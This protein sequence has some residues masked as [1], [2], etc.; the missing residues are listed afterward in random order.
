VW[1]QGNG[2][3]RS[4]ACR[5][6]SRA[7]LGRWAKKEPRITGLCTHTHTSREIDS[8]P[9]GESAGGPRALLVGG[10]G[11]AP[12]IGEPEPIGRASLYRIAHI[13]RFFL[14]GK[15]PQILTLSTSMKSRI[16][17]IAFAV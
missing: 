15:T 11:E 1:P 6:F 8:K 4:T 5:R 13:A 14:Y 7:E 9:T 10:R 2:G 17:P 12:G 3:Q 16:S